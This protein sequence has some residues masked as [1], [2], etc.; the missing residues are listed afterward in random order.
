MSLNRVAS[1]ETFTVL[2]VPVDQRSRRSS[3]ALSDVRARKLSFNPL[4]EEWDA[5]ILDQVHAVSAFEVPK[6][7]RIRKWAS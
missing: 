5:A 7:K 3:D 6:W 1:L 2:Q 4:P